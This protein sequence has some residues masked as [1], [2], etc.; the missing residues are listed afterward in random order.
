M[1]NALA[2]NNNPSRR[3][4]AN[5]NRVFPPSYFHEEFTDPLLAAINDYRLTGQVS[6]AAAAANAGGASSRCS[7]W[8]DHLTRLWLGGTIKEIEMFESTVATRRVGDA[9]QY[10]DVPSEASDPAAR[11]VWRRSRCLR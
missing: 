11:E 3:P 1:T 8:L 9:L 7:R 4:P 2:G 6:P 10:R 5:C